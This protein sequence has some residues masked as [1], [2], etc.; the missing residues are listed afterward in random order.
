MRKHLWFSWKK[1]QIKPVE[2]DWPDVV[3]NRKIFRAFIWAAVLKG[4]WFLFIDESFFNPRKLRYKSWI[5]K[6]DPKAVLQL[7]YSK[8]VA[9]MCALSDQGVLYS[10]CWKGTNSAREAL[11]FFIDLERMLKEKEGW[12]Y[13]SYR[14]KLI[15]CFDNAS[16]H[17]TDEIYTFFRVRG[18]QVVTLPQYTPEWNPVEKVFSLVKTRLVR[19]NLVTE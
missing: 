4:A 2:S 9:A 7:N 13:E 16:I 15:I 11:L 6:D 17:L 10:V 12:H 14:K 1:P 5:S 8:G 3:Q 19:S 18:L